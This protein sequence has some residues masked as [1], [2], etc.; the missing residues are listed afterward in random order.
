MALP[1]F[2]NFDRGD[3]G[4]VGNGWS[5]TDP[6][7][8]L[9]IKDD[10]LNWDAAADN[11]AYAYRTGD[12]HNGIKVT[13]T[14]KYVTESNADI[15]CAKVLSDSSGYASGFG[16]YYH[17][18]TNRLYIHGTADS[19][20][21]TWNPTAGTLYNVEM[22]IG[23]DYATE[24]RVW[25]D[26]DSRPG[27]ATVSVGATTPNYQTGT[28]WQIGGNT[29][30]GNP[31]DIE[32]N[33]YLVET[34]ILPFLDD[35]D[36]GDSGT[37]GN[38]WT[39][40][41][42]S[43]VLGIKDNMLNWDGSSDDNAFIYRDGHSISKGI[44]ITFTYK[45][46]SQTN[47]QN[48]AFTVL[49][50][51]SGYANG[52]G[53]NI[54]PY[55]DSKIYFI[56]S[57]AAAEDSAT[58]SFTEGVLYQIEIIIFP[59]YTGEIRI[60]PDSGSR[61]DTP[62]LTS[63]ETS[64]NA[65]GAYWHVGGNTG[66]GNPLDIEV[67]NYLVETWGYTFTGD[68]YLSSP[69][70]EA[71][72]T[73]DA[74]LESEE[75][76]TFTSDANLIGE[77]VATYTSDSNLVIEDISA[78]FTSD[79]NL[80]STE[81]T[82]FTGDANLLLENISSTFTSDANLKSTESTSFTG[83]ANLLLENISSTFTSDANLKSVESTSFTSDANLKSVE[84][85]TFTGDANLKS[86]ETTTFTGDAALKYI[87]EDSFTG[88]SNLIGETSTSF[89]GNS[90]LKK[91]EITTFTG[92]SMLISS[93]TSTFS[94]DASLKLV[95]TTTFSGDASLLSVESNTFT[96]DS[97]LIREVSVTFSGDANL[98]LENISATFTGDA[99]L[100]QVISTSLTSDANLKSVEITTFTSDANLSINV[101]ETFTGDASL[102]SIE[103]VTFTGDANL[104]SIESTSFT[105]NAN[106]TGEVLT[107]FTGDTNLKRENI[108]TTFTGDA[109]LLSV[110]STSFT[111]DANL[112]SAETNTFTGD[113][114]IMTEY[115]VT[116]TGDASLLS[117]E[118]TSFTGDALLQAIDYNGFAGII[119]L[120]NNEQTY[121]YG[122]SEAMEFPLSF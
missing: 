102:L 105:G 20:Y 78:T 80:K 84:S 119:T 33:N 21:E 122:L 87:V 76:N 16:L 117:T 96:G 42:A 52:Y 43:N 60:W 28:N 59:D 31:L 14:L 34:N 61:P 91:V 106:L 24:I 9:G 53:L 93:Y 111:G 67:N 49:A 47:R 90:N 97:N 26:G 110:E 83:D 62:T 113:S 104:L 6:S 13:F 92:D 88:D 107:T 82:S 17:A 70:I 95:I 10:K 30:G 121:G 86:V 46:V 32:V 64:P 41:D 108:T 45:E 48:F 18:S 63:S 23:L 98:L 101:I 3:S 120:D 56:D 89:T 57:G 4:T 66:G 85:S 38:D 68:S 75:S 54:V 36:R 109:S 39:E 69:P 35:F 8:V 7:G 29:G 37:V 73:G 11:D 77:V 22:L 19:T 100:L 25:A 55:P 81:S 40:T 5:E 44:K 99:S 15:F 50:D 12:E 116:F 112:Q 58:F 71:T 94:G 72:F 118:S 79:A 27:S 115:I 74:S 2:D 103:S 65:T 1:F 51:G 114:A